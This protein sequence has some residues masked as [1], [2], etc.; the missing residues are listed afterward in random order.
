M[1]YPL[2]TELIPHSDKMLFIEK[3]NSIDEIGTSFL[4][5]TLKNDAFYF[6][7]NIFQAEWFIEFMAQAAGCVFSYTYSEKKDKASLGFL[8][9]VDYFEIL[10]D[11]VVIL[12]PGD[13]LLFEIKKISDFSEIRKYQCKVIFN[14]VYYAISEMKFIV[15]NNK[16]MEI[17]NEKVFLTGGSK[18]IGEATV[19][20]FCLQK[21]YS[22]TFT[23]FNNEEKAKNIVNEINNLGGMVD[24][25][26]LN[27]NNSEE[28]N[29]II[30]K[31]VEEKKGF[32]IIIHNAA[33][34][35]DI[36]LYFMSEGEWRDVIHTSLNSFFY[37]NKACLKN[38]IENRYGRIISL[39]SVAGEAGNRGQ[40]NYSA[41]KGAII[42]ASKSLAREVAAKGITVN[43]VSPGLIDTEMT[44]HLPKEEIKKLIPMARFGSPEEVT[45]VIAFL[46]SKDASY[47]TG[48]VIR[49]NG[50]LYT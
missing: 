17:S 42:S 13:K 28:T 49:V 6:E 2:I 21:K 22:V 19:R 47:V 23:Y 4:E 43:C 35:K 27:L 40:T 46:A 50:G 45:G 48:E 31:L 29:F 38:M 24:C 16:D 41:A 32:D 37:I 11:N 1:I 34:N 10:D 44:L 33:Q 30:N 8:L 39:V 20:Y 26:Y 5:M 12:K 18:G 7:D 9:S 14:D 3:I 25:V 36:P 15:K